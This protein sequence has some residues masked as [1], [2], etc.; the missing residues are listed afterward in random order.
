MA[1]KP[2]ARLKTL[3][4]QLCMTVCGAISRWAKWMQR[5]NPFEMWR[6]DQDAEIH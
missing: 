2:I 1:Y 6:D 4:L 5:H 3:R